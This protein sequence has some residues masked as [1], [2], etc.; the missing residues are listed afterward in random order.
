M[1]HE[2]LHGWFDQVAPASG[3]WTD[4][5]NI[6]SGDIEEAPISAIENIWYWWIFQKRKGETA[7]WKQWEEKIALWARGFGP[8]ESRIWV[9]ITNEIPITSYPR[10]PGTRPEATA[11]SKPSPSKP[12]AAPQPLPKPPFGR[13]E[14]PR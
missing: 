4:L 6:F 8:R 11:V 5:R 14:L 3:G 7:S 1:V 10:L 12:K 13:P 9:F 2:L